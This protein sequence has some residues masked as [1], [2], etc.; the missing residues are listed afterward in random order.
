MSFFISDCS[1]EETAEVL[2]VNTNDNITFN[3]NKLLIGKATKFYMYHNGKEV[4][5][6]YPFKYRLRRISQMDYYK[7]TL[8]HSVPRDS[9]QTDSYIT[10]LGAKRSDNGTYLFVDVGERS[11]YVCFAVFVYGKFCRT[12][13]SNI[14]VCT[15]NV[16]AQK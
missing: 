14:H 12:F 16:T 6:L 15:N 4:G 1:E 2:F 13:N 5:I 7:R 11:Y 3:I 9:N 8:F 10:I